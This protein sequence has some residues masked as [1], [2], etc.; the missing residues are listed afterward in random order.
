[1]KIKKPDFKKLDLKKPDLTKMNINK[2]EI[3]LPKLHLPGKGSGK[4][5][6]EERQKDNQ[7]AA[8]SDQIAV[9]RRRVKKQE[10]LNSPDEPT[11]IQPEEPQ[12][13][14]R[15]R[16]KAGY[17]RTADKEKEYDVQSHSA[18]RKDREIQKLRKERLEARKKEAMKMR[19]ILVG[20]VAAVLLVVIL[21]LT[22]G[23]K[24]KNR[25]APVQETATESTA[26][27]A[28]SRIW[29]PGEIPHFS[30]RMLL[31]DVM[32]SDNSILTMDQ[33]RQALQQL[34][35]QGYVLV[36]FYSLTELQTNEDGSKAY[37]NKELELPAGK[38]PFILS[39]RDVSYP[40]DH[41]GKGYASRLIVGEDGSIM[42][43][44]Q[45]M[46][47]SVQAG[48][49]DVVT[50]L[51][52]FITEHPDFSYEG[53]KGVLGLTGYNGIFGYRTSEMLGHSSEEGNPYAVYGT[54]D[55]NAEIEASKVV[56]E[57]LKNKGWHLASYGYNYCS[58]GA[59]YA[60][61]T[62]DLDAWMANVS[63]IIG[64]TDILIFPCE[65]D[66]GNW[67]EYKADNQKY[68]YL[69]AKG[70][71]YFCIEEKNNPSW[72]QL[73]DDYVRQGI[74]EID[75]WDDFVQVMEQQAE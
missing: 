58:Y 71:S 55:V 25:P 29:Q 63:S 6:D 53:A 18:Q 5:P 47:G 32:A 51:E 24:I 23:R 54:F 74:K 61:M 52:E 38:K 30:F 66:I 59:E 64:G 33:F 73:R 10:V 43:E 15:K 57:A 50:I 42:N 62:S 9:R 26:E 49:Y 27:E 67:S 22:L 44:Y 14:R 69:K 19:F 1:M 4:D 36:D 7:E 16:Y 3:H 60:M 75:C 21:G 48:A 28:S 35:D 41:V 68:Q 11:E 72:M 45:N 13:G 40:L 39:Q 56:T 70:F 65:T 20:V 37:V 34:Y 46:D 31:S 2:S 8:D 12:Y 17:Q